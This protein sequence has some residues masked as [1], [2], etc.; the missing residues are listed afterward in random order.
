[1][2]IYVVCKYTVQVF[3][4]EKQTHERVVRDVS[5]KDT[6]QDGRSFET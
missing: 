6:V 4:H 1:M 3:R 2:Y 5:Q